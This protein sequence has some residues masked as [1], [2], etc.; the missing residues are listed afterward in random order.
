MPPSIFITI[1]STPPAAESQP[2]YGPTELVAAGDAW[3]D[4]DGS[5]APRR[6]FS[7]LARA[8]Y[9]LLLAVF[10]APAGLEQKPIAPLGLVHEDLKQARCS[11][12]F[13]FV[14]QLVRRAHRDDA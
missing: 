14:A 4:P 6:G 2:Q 7:A 3:L 13:M 5:I 9:L 12:I 8:R 1:N 10:T 11:D